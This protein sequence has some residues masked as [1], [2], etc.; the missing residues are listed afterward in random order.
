MLAQRLV[1]KDERFFSFK[2][3]SSRQEGSPF[4]VCEEWLVVY[5]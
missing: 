2:M 4:L 3:E 1:V 5:S